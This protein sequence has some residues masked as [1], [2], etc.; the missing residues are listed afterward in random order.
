[1]TSVTSSASA[2]RTRVAQR[3]DEH[4]ERAAERQSQSSVEVQE[5]L[6]RRP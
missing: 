6:M 2:P 5:P 3:Q 4:G 1:M